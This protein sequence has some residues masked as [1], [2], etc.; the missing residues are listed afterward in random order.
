MSLEIDEKIRCLPCWNGPVTIAP[1]SGGLS[2]ANYLVTDSSG[3]HV[4]RFGENYPFHHVYRDREVMVARAAHAAGFAPDVQHAAHGTMVT[5]F[6]SAKTFAAADVKA[7]VPRIG[8]L[9]RRFH[10]E[11]PKR[12]TGP[13]F[14][15]H[16][17]HVIRDYINTLDMPHSKYISHAEALEA[18]QP[19]LPI[20][21][22]H[23][24]LLPANVLDDG[25]KLWLIDFEY[26][27]FGTCLFDLA[28]ASSNS[29]LEAEEQQQLL[30]AYFG[31]PP[32]PE[33]QRAFSAMECASLLREAL[34]SM[35]SAKFLTTPG[36]DYN[37]YAAENLT[38]YNAALERH[39]ST[40]GKLLP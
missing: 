11:M 12:I 30:A 10:T 19:P 28:N 16:V 1:L 6:L 13:A 22:G 14:L 15:F 8:K 26:A 17:F 27:G 29:Q 4:V 23:H 24:D 32:S 33:M 3:K 21:F 35:V 39:Q 36:V 34:W 37:A 40:Y 20:I 31:K 9:L 5:A 25:E 18:Q 7:N 38:R 2:N